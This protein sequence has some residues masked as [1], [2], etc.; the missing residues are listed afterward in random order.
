MVLVDLLQLVLSLMAVASRV[1]HCQGCAHVQLV[2]LLG[3]VA[4]AVIHCRR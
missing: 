2:V 4:G 1:F 3:A